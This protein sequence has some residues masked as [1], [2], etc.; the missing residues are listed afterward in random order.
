MSTRNKYDKN[1]HIAYFDCYLLPLAAKGSFF[2]F[3]F[4]PFPC[5]KG[6]WENGNSSFFQRITLQPKFGEAGIF[7]F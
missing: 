2:F 3:G 7:V 4:T 5:W 6:F 1:A